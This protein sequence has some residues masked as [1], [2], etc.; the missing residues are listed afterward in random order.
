[1]LAIIIKKQNEMK[2]VGTING[3][4]ITAYDPND[5]DTIYR[6]SRRLGTQDPTEEDWL[7]RFGEG[8]FIRAEP[9]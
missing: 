5:Y 2:E 1:M 6:L 9:K 8:T 4:E 7:R 3:K